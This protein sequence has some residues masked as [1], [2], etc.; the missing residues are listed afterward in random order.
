MAAAEIVA[1]RLVLGSEVVRVQPLCRQF[2]RGMG[3]DL[4]GL[5]M[6]AAAPTAPTA[7]SAPPPPP[8]SLAVALAVR[9]AAF[10]LALVGWPAIGLNRLGRSFTA[11]DL[12]G[13]ELCGFCVSAV[14]LRWYMRTL[15]AAFLA[16]APATSPPAAPAAAT[17]L[18]FGR[19]HIAL[20]RTLDVGLAALDGLGLLSERLGRADFRFF[21]LLLDE[22]RRVG[23]E[24][25]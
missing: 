15:L 4:A 5:A 14:L 16:A 17:L 24:G 7:A 8:A 20:F 10:V 13:D 12:L 2:A 22:G 25:R 1:V 9:C 3:A 19:M 11:R 18:A 23:D 21:L 6:P